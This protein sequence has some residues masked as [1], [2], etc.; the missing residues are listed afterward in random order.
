MTINSIEQYFEA[1]AAC[2]L[3]FD[4]N[5]LIPFFH[6]PCIVHDLGGVHLIDSDEALRLY[7]RSMLELLRSN[8]ATFVK[9]KVKHVK[10]ATHSLCSLSCTVEYILRDSSGKTLLDF[11]YDYV[12]VGEEGA[13][14]ILFAQIGPL[15]SSSI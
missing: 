15:R 6:Y 9:S 5:V 1:Y 14:R 13:W 10:V 3:T 11:D 12:L 4:A 8:D 7:E 2:Y